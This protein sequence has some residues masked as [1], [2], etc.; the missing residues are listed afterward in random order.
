MHLLGL[1]DTHTVSEVC[2]GVTRVFCT[3]LECNLVDLCTDLGDDD[4]TDDFTDNFSL[5]KG[6]VD[7]EHFFFFIGGES[8]TKSDSSESVMSNFCQFRFRCK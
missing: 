3:G 4:F 2:V 5:G 8:D 7:F 1:G 6:F